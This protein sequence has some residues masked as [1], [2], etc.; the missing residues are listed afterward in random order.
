MVA[1]SKTTLVVGS[2]NITTNDA[3][4]ELL[5][6]H[7]IFNQLTGLRTNEGSLTIGGGSFTTKASFSNTGKL[8]VTSGGSVNITSSKNLSG[9]TLTGGTWVVDSSGGTSKTTLVVG[10]GNITTNDAN[11]E[12]LG[13]HSIFNQ[14]TGLRTNQGSLT[15]GTGNSFTIT[16]TKIA[17]TN[18]GTLATGIGG[19]LV[20]SG[21]LTDSG[22]ITNSG[23]LT[24]AGT[25]SGNGTLNNTGTLT[26]TS[27]GNVNISKSKNL[28]DGKLIGGTWVVDS[29]AGTGTAK[30]VVGSGDITINDANI[31]LLGAHSS[32]SQLSGLITNEGSLTVGGGSF[33]TKASFG[34][35]GT[36]T[37]NSG[38]NVNIAESKNLSGG[39]LT[40]GTWV[41]DSSGSSSTGTKATTKATLVVG[42]GNIT[43]NDA[44]I[45]LLG[46]NAS[47]GQLNG[48]NTNKGSLT[49]G[50]GNSFKASALNNTGTLAVIS[51]GSVNI[52]SSKN[53]SGGTLTGG[54]WVVDSS[55]G[56]SKTTLVVGS[57][58]ITT[59]DAN[60]ELLGAH[61]IFN[62]LTGLRTNQGSLTVGGGGFT[63]KAS[64]SNT[65][66]LTVTSG[67]SVN[68]TSSKNLSGGTL[69]GGTWVVDSSGGSKATLAVGTGTITTNDAKIELLGANSSF[70]QLTGLRTNEGLLTIGG[71]SF[72]T[73]KTSLNNTGTLIVTSGGNV[74]H[75]KLQEPVR[76]NAEGRHLGS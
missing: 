26:V 19:T 42:S 31:E 32:F 17:L 22:L 48:L 58:N 2:G 4:I 13:A 40:G 35:T 25:I 70:S 36:L 12:L 3:N 65:G 10:G 38:G 73:D 5:G 75:H 51:G 57:G 33:T 53:L 16:N 37:V 64:F 55:G 29:S 71:G 9:G 34:N 45:E 24:S 43:T 14:L 7:S 50:G 15:I 52:T 69:T 27:G 23:S 41:V 20:N 30:L 39:T 66:K 54:T 60:I 18:T 49:I 1:A 59:N 67:G 68:I 8:T 47:F 11:I 74:E 72:T 28:S 62:Q 21:K 6:A 63:T 61:S 56:T 46:A 76:R 44:T